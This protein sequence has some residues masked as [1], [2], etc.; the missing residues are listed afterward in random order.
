MKEAIKIQN[1]LDNFKHIEVRDIAL[2][3]LAKAQEQPTHIPEIIWKR[4]DA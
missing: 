4:R 2:L 3:Q 1:E